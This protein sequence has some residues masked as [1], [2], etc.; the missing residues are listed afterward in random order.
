MPKRNQ[1]Q[2]VSV[3]M[4]SVNKMGFYSPNAFTHTKYKISFYNNRHVQ[5]HAKLVAVGHHWNVFGGC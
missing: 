4:P 3:G 1:G 5:P 2:M